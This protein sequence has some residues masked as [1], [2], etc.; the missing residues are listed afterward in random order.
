MDLSRS[1]TASN[2]ENV[3]TACCV[4]AQTFE[5]QRERRTVKVFCDG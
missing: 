1:D 3:I 4:R 5:K 2:I